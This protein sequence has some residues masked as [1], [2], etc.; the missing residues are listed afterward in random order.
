MYSLRSQS[1]DAAAVLGVVEALLAGADVDKRDLVGD[2]P[3]HVLAMHSHAQP[4]AAPAA[5]LLLGNGARAPRI[6]ASRTIVRCRQ[7]V[8]AR[9]GCSCGG[10]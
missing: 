5:R 9:A 4:W 7:D 6:G 8:D 10:P 3:L 1:A 2:T